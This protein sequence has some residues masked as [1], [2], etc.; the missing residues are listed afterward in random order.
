MAK[1]KTAN[2]FEAVALELAALAKTIESLKKSK[3]EKTKNAKG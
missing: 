3:D 2:P 1:H